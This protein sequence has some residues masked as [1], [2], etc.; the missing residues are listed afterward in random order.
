MALFVL[1][2]IAL[3][4]Y[5]LTVITPP[6]PLVTSKTV[7][8]LASAAPT[9]TPVPSAVPSAAPVVPPVTPRRVL[10][11]LNATT[12]WRAATGSCP[13][14]R[15]MPERSTD[16]GATWTGFDAGGETGATAVLVITALSDSEASFVT[17]LAADC[18]PHLMATY[19]AGA[20]WD[21]FPLRLT[22]NWYVNPAEPATV[23][24]PLGAFAAPCPAPITLAAQ[25]DA[26]GAVLCPPVQPADAAASAP[27]LV[28]T[29][30]GGSSW[31]PGVAVPGAVNLAGL[32]GGGYVIA[33][34][35][36]AGCAG[37]QVLTLADAAD[38]APTVAGCREAA[39]EPGDV[40]IAS[41]PGVLWLWA[42]AIMSTSSDGGATW[43]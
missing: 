8:A 26:S 42:G 17:L 4:V 10:S 13:D 2:D 43:P 27:M 20:D 35:G 24:S 11:S 1:V 9:P 29:T 5:A 16:S 15:A 25:S 19:V 28:R 38:A 34:A 6:D 40:A 23:H 12:A 31:T 7:D 3:V 36:Q 32:A 30:D 37:V 33:A 22:G 41:S 39:F 14:A 18:T 21:D